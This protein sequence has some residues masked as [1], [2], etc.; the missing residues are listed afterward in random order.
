MD[1]RYGSHTVFQIEYHFVWVTK[2]RHKVLIGEVAIRV[3]ELVRQTCEAFEIRILKGVVSK[4]HV[5]ILVSSPPTLSPSEIMRRLKGRTASKLFEEFSHLKK[6][7]WGQ[8]FWGR[9]YFCATV[10][11]LTEEMIKAYLE[12]HFE[13]NPDDNFRM[14]N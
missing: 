8:H 10:G 2:Y 3:R 13:P 5:H 14:D 12:H 6:R 11:Q 4:D 1:Y 7:Y 9:G